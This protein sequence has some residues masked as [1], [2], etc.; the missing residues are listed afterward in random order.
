IGGSGDVAFAASVANRPRL[1][2]YVWRAASNAIEAI[3]QPGDSAP[4][5]DVFERAILPHVN[6]HGDVLFTGGILRDVGHRRRLFFGLYLA[7]GGRIV[8]IAKPGDVM[9]DGSSF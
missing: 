9:P 7:A 2:V 8:S 1:G 4:G 3:A 5:G 6:A